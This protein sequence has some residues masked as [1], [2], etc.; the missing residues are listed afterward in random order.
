[1]KNC[2]VKDCEAKHYA[3][4]YCKIHYERVGRHG[5]PDKKLPG[6]KRK[7][8]PECS[9]VDCHMPHV[10]YGYCSKHRTRFDR[11]GDP[12]IIRIKNTYGE[13]GTGWRDSSG[14]KCR[15]IN[16]KRI[17]EHTLVMEKILGRKLLSHEN[18]HH[19]N[20]VRDDNRPE[21]LE[22][23]SKSQPSGQRVIDKIKW[24]Q[25]ILLRYQNDIPLLKKSKLAL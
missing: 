5:S 9:V 3:K 20:G 13:F 17:R 14:Y 10:S 18:V 7:Y 8:D 19:V 4:G 11:H 21:N 22:L 12:L 2:S 1:M 15:W 25:E 6:G 23:W 24:A 16:G